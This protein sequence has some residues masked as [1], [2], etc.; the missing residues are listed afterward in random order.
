M[1]LVEQMLMA[2]L[3]QSNPQGYNAL[4][5]MRNSGMNPQQALNKLLSEGLITQEQVNQATNMASKYETQNTNYR[6]F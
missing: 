3:K 5:Q 6:R 1:N 2:K 4:V